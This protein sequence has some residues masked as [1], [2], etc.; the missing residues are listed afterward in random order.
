MNFGIAQ[1]RRRVPVALVA[2][3]AVMLAFHYT[4]AGEA[5]YTVALGQV[6]RGAA[7]PG[8]PARTY[9]AATTSR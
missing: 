6:G 4:A 8:E 3:L 1:L 2:N 5:L 7:G 9:E